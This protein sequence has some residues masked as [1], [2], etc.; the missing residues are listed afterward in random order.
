MRKK[1]LIL[2]PL[3][4]RKGGVA[5]YY[6]LLKKYFKAEDIQIDYFFTG[7]RSDEPSYVSRIINSVRDLID[8]IFVIKEY[9]VV[10]LNPS[11]DF[12]GVIRDGIYHFLAKK[13]YRKKTIVF[14][15]GWSIS[16]ERYINNKIF[17]RLFRYFFNFDCALVLANS[18]KDTLISWGYN[19]DIIRL[20]TTTVDDTLLE[21]FSIQERINLIDSRSEIQLL[22]LARI[23][24]KKGI[25]ETIKAFNLLNKVCPNVRLTVAG[26]GSFLDEARRLAYEISKERVSFVGYVR[27]KEK[28]D[29]LLNSDIY[30]FPT[31]YREGMPNSVLE[32]MAMGLPVITRPVAGLKDFFKDGA[33]GFMIDSKNPQDIAACIEKIIV[34]KNLWKKMAETAHEY[35]INRFLCS[36]VALRLENIYRNI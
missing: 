25:M 5:N 9:D 14:F 7:K 30:V 10:H 11:L 17:T 26:I 29:I 6:R 4:D 16:F 32:A 35:A 28:K 21:D 20:E 8:L 33:H 34:D 2:C 22:F 24:E 12:N 23:E 18:F 15:R 13:I 1:I 27:G 36:N 19:P 31:Y 3:Q